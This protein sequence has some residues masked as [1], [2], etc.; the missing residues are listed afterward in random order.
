MAA[1][2][3]RRTNSHRERVIQGHDEG[4]DYKNRALLMLLRI[5]QACQL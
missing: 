2:G 3:S 4:K 1:I 5:K